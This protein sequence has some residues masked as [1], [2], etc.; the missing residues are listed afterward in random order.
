MESIFFGLGQGGA[1]PELNTTYVR[2]ERHVAVPSSDE[3]QA[4]VTD[5][6]DSP[7]KALSPAKLQS[8]LCKLLN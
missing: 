6:N 5:V 2:G 3:P 8:Q 4:V 1:A 7:E